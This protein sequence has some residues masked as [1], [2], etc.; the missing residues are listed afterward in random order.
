M[1]LNRLQL[2]REEMRHSNLDFLLITDPSN[3]QWIS[4]FTG[5]SGIVLISKQTAYIATDSRYWIQVEQQSPD[6]ELVKIAG[7]TTSI[8]TEL[9]EKISDAS[10]FGYEPENLTMKQ[11]QDYTKIISSMTWKNTPNFIAAPSI[12]NKLRMSK[13]SGE[14]TSLIKAVEIADA[15]MNHAFQI[16]QPGMTEKTLA[17]EIQKYVIENGADSLSFNTIVAGGERGA[18]PHARPLNIALA[19]KTGVVIDM[20]VKVNGYCSDLTR[21]FFLGT[22]TDKFKKVYDVVLTAQMMAIERIEVGMTG[23]EAHEIAASVIAEMGYG[24]YFGHGLGHGVGI[25]VH[26]APRL[27]PA[28]DTILE[29]GHVFTIEPGIYL[30]GWGGVRIEDQCLMEAGKVRSLTKSPKL[31]LEIGVI[32]D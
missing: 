30:P 24:N 19:N 25:D 13:D 31:D 16:I 5:S 6:F 17:W 22:P 10:N 27:S 1:I 32:N 8:A 4:G 7:A 18:L 23:A 20:G 21:T 14:L 9:I 3:R 15:G 28:S 11:Y 29:N 12:I 2:V 26:E